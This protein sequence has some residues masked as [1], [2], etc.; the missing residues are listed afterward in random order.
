MT[1]QGLFP[2]SEVASMIAAGKVLLLAGDEAS[3]SKLPAGSWIGG[4]SANFMAPDGGKTDQENIFVTDI[5]DFAAKVETRIYSLH[6]LSSIASHYP[7]NGF[8]V[9]ILPGMSEIH[10][11]FAKDVQSYDGVFNAPL[12]GWISGVHVSEIGK[13]A[14]KVFAGS[15]SALGN[16]AAVFHVTLPEGHAAK[17]DIVNLFTQGEGEVITFE[18]NGFS[19]EG[20][21]MIGGKKANLAAYIG[22]N[23][24]DTKLPLVADYNGAMV[25]VSVQN[26]DP[27]RGRV[28]FYAPVFKGMTYRFAKPVEDYTGQFSKAIGEK[29]VG[30]V[31]FSCNCI[32]NF[33][34]AE[35]EGKKTGSLVGPITF[36]EIAFMLLNQTLVYLSVEKV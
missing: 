15:G 8:N 11:S 20:D 9:I 23:K 34:Y 2:V 5:S 35:L 33:L 21:C 4:S 26:V 18:A 22:D 12:V 14:P 27:A 3:L 1:T 19:T 31:A 28:D 17:V 16:Q 7:E 13:R 30:T 24:I 10:G 25:N 36:G 6:E 32:L 29:S